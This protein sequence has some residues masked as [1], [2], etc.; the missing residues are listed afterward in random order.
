[1]PS[2]SLLDQLAAEGADRRVIDLALGL[3]MGIP[4][5]PTHSP[6]LYSMNKLHGQV[7]Y[8]NGVGVVTDMFSMGCHVG[9]HFDALGHVSCDGLLHGGVRA[10]E[11]QTF[12][13]GLER[14]G[15]QELQPVVARGV[16]LDAPAW[17]GLSR[18]PAQQGIGSSEI[19]AICARQGL[20]ITAG[21]AVLLRT[22]WVQHWPDHVAFNASPCP[23][24]TL[25]GAKW[26]A[27]RGVSVIGADN[28]ALE[29]VPAPGLP[30]HV[31]LLV[32]RG[33]PIIEML[34]LE[35]LAGTGDTEFVFIAA[36]LKIM[37]GSGAPTR[38]IALLRQ[39]GG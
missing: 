22:G 33:I 10:A 20:S 36:P 13:K 4:H 1:M 38:P 3:R 31:E 26:L 35:E 28:Y 7:A 11:V 30:V 15:A 25:D 12:D 2:A 19:E 23:G 14:H 17:M 9:T 24:L 5:G 18:L 8:P 6:Y 39:A 29:Q 16:L 32:R 34:D 37:G 27:D 21:D